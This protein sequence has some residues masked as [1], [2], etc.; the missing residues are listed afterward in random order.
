M[1]YI[2]N[3]LIWWCRVHACEKREGRAHRRTLAEMICHQNI[4]ILQES[5]RF[6]Y[7]FMSF[8]RFGCVHSNVASKIAMRTVT[9]KSNFCHAYQ[10][11]VAS[12]NC[13]LHF[14]HFG[15]VNKIQELP[16]FHCAFKWWNFV[17]GASAW[18]PNEYK[19]FSWVENSLES[20]TLWQSQSKCL[21][22]Q[23]V[24][25]CHTNEIR[26]YILQQQQWHSALF[27]R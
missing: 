3:C 23:D 4:I 27:R 15:F 11:F 5:P 24:K 14:R 25:T 19:I 9:I 21:H 20:E 17:E 1:T 10:K 26:D 13:H 6:N 2:C 22:F 12:C 7:K 8:M 16:H 18:K